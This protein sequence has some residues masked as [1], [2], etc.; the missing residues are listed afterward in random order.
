MF[1]VG[2]SLIEARGSRMSTKDPR[3]HQKRA[4]SRNVSATSTTMGCRRTPKNAGETS[5]IL[6]RCREPIETTITSDLN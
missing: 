2:G 5:A 3:T 1:D 6:R 4:T